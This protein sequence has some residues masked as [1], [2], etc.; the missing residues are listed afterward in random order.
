L[1][2][3]KMRKHVTISVMTKNVKNEDVRD[4]WMQVRLHKRVQIG[5]TKKSPFPKKFV[6]VDASIDTYY[7]P[8]R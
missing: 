5:L 4:A 8:F 3:L 7:F 1:N 2:K 6:H